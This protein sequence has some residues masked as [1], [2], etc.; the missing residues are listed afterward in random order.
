MEYVNAKKEFSQR[1]VTLLNF[2]GTHLRCYCHERGALRTFKSNRIRGIFHP[3]T[4]EMFYNS[5]GVLHEWRHKYT[6]GKTAF[7][8]CKEGLQILIWLARVDGRIVSEEIPVMMDFIRD[9][10]G[11]E[12]CHSYDEQIL[13]D[14]IKNQYP[15]PET[16]ADCARSFRSRKNKVRSILLEHA[17]KLVHADGVYCEQERAAM[18]ALREYFCL[19]VDENIA[20]GKSVRKRRA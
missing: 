12:G 18:D 5:V 19:N 15:A 11:E 3:E 6:E 10:C 9:V 7:D 1:R 13:L 2:T 14:W 17:E 8:K 4:G 16:V 20:D